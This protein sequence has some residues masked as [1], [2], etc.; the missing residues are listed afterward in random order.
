[1]ALKK[2]F[3]KNLR[4]FTCSLINIYSNKTLNLY[5]ILKTLNNTFKL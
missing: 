2:I 3:K 4:Y 1:M 5:F